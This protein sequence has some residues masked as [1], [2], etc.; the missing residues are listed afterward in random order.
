[1]GYIIEYDS[2]EKRYEVRRTYPFRFGLLLAAAVALFLFLSFQFWP[3]GSAFL[4]AAL[5]P[6]EEAVT[7]QAFENLTQDLKAGA[8]M[9]EALEAFCVEVIHSENAA[10]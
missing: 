9:A 1:M 7:V 4:R 6:G 10:D 5:I 3:K 2:F 8:P